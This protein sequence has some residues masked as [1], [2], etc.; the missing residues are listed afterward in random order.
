MRTSDQ[1]LVSPT[2]ALPADQNPLTLRF[3]NWRQIEQSAAACWD[4]GILEVS[5]DGGTQFTQVPNNKII[6]G[7][8]YRGPVGSGF[9]NPLTGLDAWCSDPA[10]PYTDGPV[11][12]DLAD[13][14]GQ[15]INLRFRLG[16]DSSVAKEGWYVDDIQINGCTSVDAIF[17]DGFDLP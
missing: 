11:L 14:A 7:G 4:G 9:N 5:T 8:G 3:A 12:I 16:T 15:S 10:R 13:Y 17:A 1:R 6:A 2:I